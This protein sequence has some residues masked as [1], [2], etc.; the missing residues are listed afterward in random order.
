MKKSGLLIL[1]IFVLAHGVI[2]A[3]TN[4]FTYQGKLN[5]GGA[6]S[7]IAFDGA[8]MWVSNNSGNVTGLSPA[9]P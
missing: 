5:D 2:S 4:S 7:E 1:I 3:Q 6:P 8:N 9:F